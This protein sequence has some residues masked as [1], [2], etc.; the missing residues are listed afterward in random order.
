[1]LKNKLCRKEKKFPSFALGPGV[2][3]NG[4]SAKMP[5]PGS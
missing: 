3:V 1:M 2:D 4:V 5:N